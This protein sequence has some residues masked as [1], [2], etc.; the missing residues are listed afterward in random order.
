[1]IG[2]DIMSP[3]LRKVEG[4]DRID[5]LNSSLTRELNW[6]SDMWNEERTAYLSERGK[7]IELEEKVRELESTVS[8]YTNVVADLKTE[9]QTLTK[10]RNL[11]KRQKSN[12]K[13]TA[14]Q[15]K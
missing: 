6:F 15:K 9:I 2:N 14:A 5:A 11:S 10:T 12:Y 3:P 1:M 13:K 4:A 7:N 8:H